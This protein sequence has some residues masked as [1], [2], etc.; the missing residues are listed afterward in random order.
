MRSHKWRAKG[1]ISRPAHSSA[2]RLVEAANSKSGVYAIPSTIQLTFI[3]TSCVS[4]GNNGNMQI[5]YALFRILS[6]IAQCH[7]P[8]TWYTIN[9]S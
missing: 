2:S 1:T 5:N 3:P 4:C 9:Y 6:I 8:T 7:C